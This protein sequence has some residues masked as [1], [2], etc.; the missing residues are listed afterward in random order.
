MRFVYALSAVAAGVSF[1]LPGS[2]QARGNALQ[3]L[4]TRQ[5]VPNSCQGNVRG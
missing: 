3:S 5:C 1:A 2:K 4:D